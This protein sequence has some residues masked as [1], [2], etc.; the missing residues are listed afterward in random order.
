MSELLIIISPP[1][2]SSGSNLGKE[3]SFII[4]TVSGSDTMGVYTSPSVTTTEQ[5]AVPPRISGPYEGSQLAFFLSSTPAC[6]SKIPAEITPCPPKPA[7][8]IP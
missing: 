3:G 2:L 4:I 8:R 6:A 1:F 7:I 5:L